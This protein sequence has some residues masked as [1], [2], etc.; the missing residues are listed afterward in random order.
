MIHD[1][2]LSLTNAAILNPCILVPGACVQ[3]KSRKVVDRNYSAPISSLNDHGKQS[4][5]TGHLDTTALYV[6]RKS[7]TEIS[8]LLQH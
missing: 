1:M 7:S 6:K 4:K 3:S 5:I 2:T 8:Y